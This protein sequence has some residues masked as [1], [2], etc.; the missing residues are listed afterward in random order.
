MYISLKYYWEK[1]NNLIKYEVIVIDDGSNDGSSEWISNN[2]SDIILLK[3]DGNLWW[4]GAINFGTEFAINKLKSDYVLLWNNDIF[5][6]L[7]YFIILEEIVL[8]KKFFNSIIGSK[9]LI[10][11]E[12]NSIWSVGGFFN[13]YTGSFGMYDTINSLN[14]EIY[15]DWQPGMGTLIPVSIIVNNNLWWDSKRFPQYHGDSDFT[16]RCKKAGLIILTYQKLVIY[17]DLSSTGLTSRKNIKELFLNLK[18]LKSNY[19][20]Y[21]DFLFYS[22]NG[23]IPLAYFG[24]LK[25]YYYYFGGYLKHNLFKRESSKQFD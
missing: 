10:K 14:N 21:R 16:I 24:M 23:K 15:C 3:G 25:K 13:Q 12:E 18:S 17:N 4:S 1:G 19:N 11:G 2:Y 8:D 9:I 22:K 7:N 20:I 6:S 5:P